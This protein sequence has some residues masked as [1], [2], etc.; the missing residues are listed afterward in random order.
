MRPVTGMYHFEARLHCC[1][2]DLL[3]RE[4]VCNTKPRKKSRRNAKNN[5]NSDSE[6][7]KKTKVTLSVPQFSS[8]V[9]TVKGHKEDK[10]EKEHIALQPHKLYLGE[11]ESGSHDIEITAYGNRYNSFG[12]I[13][14]PAWVGGCWPD[15]WRSKS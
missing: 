1:R 4:S 7:K 14:T 5:N 9:L 15:R 11:L 3:R 10:E 12:H 13:H 8:P 6:E 2:L